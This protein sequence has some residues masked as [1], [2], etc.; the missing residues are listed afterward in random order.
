V[1][2]HSE[3]LLRDSALPR[4]SDVE[5]RIG[6]IVE[7]AKK[8]DSLLDGLAAY[9]IALQI[10]PGSFQPVRLDILLRTVIA[11]LKKDLEA[12]SA[13]VEYGELPL[14]CGNPDRLIQLFEHLL[15]NA[16]MH[17]AEAAP[18]VSLTAAEH[19]EGWLITVRDNGRGVDEDSLETI[20]KPF[21]RLN[22]E[23]GGAGLG[24]AVCREIVE[25]HGG[26]IWAERPPEGG[27]LF[28]FTLPPA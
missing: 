17:R 20:F 16:V 22:T 3:L 9:S 12:C 14:V 24:L 26:R 2:A 28:R 7:G 13:E 4:D 18:R 25:R 15:R 5:R 19:A 27:A 23:N 21:E 1:R 8:I 10:E 6:F 11:K